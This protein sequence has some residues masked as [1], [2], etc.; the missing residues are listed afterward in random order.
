MSYINCVRQQTQCR[1]IP[2]ILSGKCLREFCKANR[3]CRA[4]PHIMGGKY[5]HEFVR[6]ID[7][8]GQ[9]HIFW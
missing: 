7:N 1:A 8:V 6:Q 5:L 2:H 3:Q 4:I 9:F